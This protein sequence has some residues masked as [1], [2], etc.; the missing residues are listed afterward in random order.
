M[1]P[2]RQ[3]HEPDRKTRRAWRIAGWGTV[4]VGGGLTA[5]AAVA[6]LPGRAGLRFF[7]LGALF[8][9]ALAALYAAGSGA[10]DAVRGRPVGRDRVVAAVVLGA[11]ATLLPAMLVGLGG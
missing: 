4:L 7:L 5:L 11:L 8:G 10:L 2:P 3:R 6:G 9:S 1:T